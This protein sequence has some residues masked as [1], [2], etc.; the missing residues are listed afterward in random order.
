MWWRRRPRRQCRW[1]KGESG[2]T[3]LYIVIVDSSF[4]LLGNLLCAHK[5]ICCVRVYGDGWC[6]GPAIPKCR[7]QP[8]KL[9]LSIYS[10]QLVHCVPADWVVQTSSLWV[11]ATVGAGNACGR[12]ARCRWRMNTIRIVFVSN[13]QW[14]DLFIL[15]QWISIFI[16]AFASIAEHYDSASEWF[17]GVD[18]AMHDRTVID[19]VRLTMRRQYFRTVTNGVSCECLWQTRPLTALAQLNGYGFFRP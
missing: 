14:S 7:S 4:L 8:A 6:C 13:F 11:N 5:F 18:V 1:R 3:V 9:L 12:I 10:G 17:F 16:T 2:P 19:G 15:R